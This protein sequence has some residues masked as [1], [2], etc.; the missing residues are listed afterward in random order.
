M[1]SRNDI[2]LEIVN[3]SSIRMRES[4]FKKNHKLLYNNI[5]NHIEKNI[6]FREKL[7]YWVNNINI[8]QT[9][10]CG[11][12]TSFN[13]NWLNG[14]KKFCSVRC[15]HKDILTHEKYKKTCLERYGV[16]NYKKTDE[17]KEKYKKTCLERYGVDNYSKT[18]EFNEKYTKTMLENYGVNHFSYTDEYKEKCV[19]TNLDRYGVDNYSKCDEYKEKCIKTNLDKYG[20]KYNI[21]S[22]NNI[23]KSKI[24]MIYKYN[25]DNYSKCDEYKEKVRNTCLDKYGVDSYVKSEVYRSDTAIGIDKNYVKYLEKGVSLF[26]CD[27]GHTFEIYINNFHTRSK[28]NITLCTICNPI[29]DSK[30]IKEKNLFEYIKSIYNGNIIQSYRDK[31]EIDIY[32]PEL[33]LGF[34][35]NGLYWHS[36][37]FKDNNYH[38]NK[39]NY[40]K[41][42]GIR[43]IHIW[44]DDWTF[45]KDIVKSQINNLLKKNQE[46]IF[47]RK[48]YI[49]LVDTKIARKFLDDNHIQG[50]VNSSIKIGLYYT[51]QSN[52]V[53]NEE[54]VSIM[55]FDQ[56]EGRVKMDSSG[57]NLSRFCNKININVV[58]GA[59]KLLNYFIKN[60]SPLRIVSYADK[61]WSIGSLYYTL[62]FEN[63][64]ES[65]PDY[66]YIVDNKRVH[67]SR[68]K[69]SKLGIQ[70]TSITEAQETKRLGIHR[71]YDCGK[72]KFEC[73]L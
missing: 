40:F 34:E 30:S 23:S 6:S 7:W 37:V 63:I 45:R 11:K 1:K 73:K 42:K 10:L 20:V 25:V 28:N 27:K 47:A 51:T 39:T 44:E 67:K 59:S 61:D 33:N 4:F 64:L 68:Y 14:Y 15:S 17:S 31:L 16:D 24:T 56:S 70:G 72:I 66:K 32:L 5:I 29:G 50:K 62:G 9:C 60:Y 43:I 13:K 22:I 53:T 46:K 21:N 49:K 54:L 36:D 69:K 71:I 18:A 65:K 38:I 48:C 58:G 12:P 3:G 57:Y 19:K 35:F 8:I 41:D 52:G 26:N 55:T 2:I